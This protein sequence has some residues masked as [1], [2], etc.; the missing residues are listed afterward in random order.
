MHRPLSGVTR[1]GSQIVWLPVPHLSPRRRI[2]Q[3]YAP[4]LLS[5]MRSSTPLPMSSALISAHSLTAHLLPQSL[6]GE[7]QTGQGDTEQWFWYPPPEQGADAGR[8][9]E[10]GRRAGAWWWELVVEPRCCW[11]Q[12]PGK[13][14]RLW[15][16]WGMQSVGSE[17]RS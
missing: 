7:T 9:D 1:T 12:M 11:V 10:M 2:I 4:T 8:W 14:H 16:F 6:P 13:Q 15:C 17:V 3:T 5:H